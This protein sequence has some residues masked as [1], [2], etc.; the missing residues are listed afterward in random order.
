MTRSHNQEHFQDLKLQ[1]TTPIHNNKIAAWKERQEIHHSLL[2]HLV[3]SSNKRPSASSAVS[4]K[5]SNFCKYRQKLHLYPQMS[6][7]HI[8]SL[9]HNIH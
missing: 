8:H 1:R 2:L 9:L 4:Q 6:Y 3:S 5:L 7:N